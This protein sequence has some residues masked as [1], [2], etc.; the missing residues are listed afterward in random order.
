MSYGKQ[1][2]ILDFVESALGRL[3]GERTITHA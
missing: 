2:L 3:V 1:I